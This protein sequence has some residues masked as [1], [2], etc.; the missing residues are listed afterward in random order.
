M[1][2]LYP[3]G[4]TLPA[5]V[6]PMQAREAAVLP[7]GED[8]VYEFLWAGERVRAVK[9]AAG[10]H[11]FSREGK[12]VTNRFPR[13]AAAVA[14]LRATN[15]ILDGEILYLDSCPGEAVRYL[16]RTTDDLSSSGLALLTYD[17][18]SDQGRDVRHFSLLCRRLMLVALVQGTPIAVSPLLPGTA[19]H[20][21]AMAMRLGLR[22]VM[23][24]RGGSAYRPNA[25]LADW[26]KCTVGAQT[27]VSP[28]RPGPSRIHGIALV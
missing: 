8:W 7:R 12:D 14:K 18:L 24:K 19:E 16:A 22:G 17:L 23:A 25:L 1:L 11:L 26:V 28:R 15:A 6:Q 20:A 27:R 5:L 21:L 3:S 13:I 2:K 9:Q 4:T 10:V